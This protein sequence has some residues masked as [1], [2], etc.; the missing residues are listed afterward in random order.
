[1]PPNQF[2]NTAY[3]M[4]NS[5][6]DI[7]N[8]PHNNIANFTCKKNDATCVGQLFWRETVKQGKMLSEIYI[9]ILDICFILKLHICFQKSCVGNQPCA[10]PASMVT[11]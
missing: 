5:P 11:V 2:E 4:C 1:M 10:W 8:W 6:L 9:M 3:K 7:I